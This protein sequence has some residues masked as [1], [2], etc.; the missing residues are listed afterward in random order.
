[1]FAGV[2]LQTVVTENKGKII[3]DYSQVIFIRKI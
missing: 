3:W 1:M 2:Y